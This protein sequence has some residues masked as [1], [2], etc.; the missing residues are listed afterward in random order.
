[1]TIEPDMNVVEILETRYLPL[2][3]EAAAR[4][5]AKHP[6]FTINVG[7]ASVGGATTFQGH[8]VY[9]EALRPNSADPEPNCVA[10]D[11]GVRDLPGTPTLC[12]LD[13][14]WGGDGIAPADGL[15]LLPAEVPFT[16]EALRSIDA[17]LPRLVEHLELCLHKWEAA[18]PHSR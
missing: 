5:R 4:L 6:T 7:S 9:L 16:T 14:A 12:S 11:I 8:D 2:L 3:D 18:Y 10:L 15:D 13:V 17:A 1:M